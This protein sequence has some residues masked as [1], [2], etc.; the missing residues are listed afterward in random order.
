[1][2]DYHK[3]LLSK[4]MMPMKLAKMKFSQISIILFKHCAS[5]LGVIQAISSFG[6]SLSNISMLLTIKELY[7]FI[8]SIFVSICLYIIYH[9]LYPVF[10]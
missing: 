5:N 9:H 10:I 6:S 3:Y 7:C 8:L 2:N 1:M 4:M